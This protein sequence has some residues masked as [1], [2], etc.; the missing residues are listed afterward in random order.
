MSRRYKINDVPISPKDVAH[1]EVLQVSLTEALVYHLLKTTH[2]AGA[3]LT[4]F[5]TKVKLQMDMRRLMLA[6]VYGMNR[7]TP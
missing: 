3:T 1:I 7:V 4:P 6:S 2:G 5:G